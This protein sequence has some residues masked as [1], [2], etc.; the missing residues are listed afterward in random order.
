[1]GPWRPDTGTHVGRL[2]ERPSWQAVVRAYTGSQT[3]PPAAP[4][5]RE[6][7]NSSLSNRRWCGR[8]RSQRASWAKQSGRCRPSRI[9]GRAVLGT[10]RR[11][12]S[13]YELRRMLEGSCWFPWREIPG[14]GG[15]EDS[16]VN[17]EDSTYCTEGFASRWPEAFSDRARC[18]TTGRRRKHARDFHGPSRLQ[19][20]H[21]PSA[22]RLAALIHF[23]LPTAL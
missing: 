5:G 6:D 22:Q 1:M 8:S 13:G 12:M 23:V 15:L 7:Q 2:V 3:L 4:S 16:R 21:W 17:G 10:M 11:D 14:V 19:V 20:S 9:M 18:T